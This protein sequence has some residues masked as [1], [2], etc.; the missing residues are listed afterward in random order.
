MASPNTLINLTGFTDGIA[1]DE[2]GIDVSKFTASVEPEFEN[3]IPGKYGAAR[4]AILGPMKL[5]GSVAGEISANTGLMAA[6]LGTAMTIANSTAYWGAPT[7]GKYLRK[8]EVEL[9]RENGKPASMSLEFWSRAASLNLIF[10]P[11]GAA[12]GN[13]LAAL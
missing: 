10:R 3:F 2:G 4:G 13:P 11:P 9:E 1:A 8:G 7:T 12:P 5:D 6:V